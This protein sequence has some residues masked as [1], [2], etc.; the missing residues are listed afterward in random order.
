MEGP[1][2]PLGPKSQALPSPP[3]CSGLLA[4]AGHCS[5]AESSPGSRR[6]SGMGA[7]DVGTFA[8][9]TVKAKRSVF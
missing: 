8:P 7:D 9:E 2:S 4:G 3:G 1:S 6:A 5:A